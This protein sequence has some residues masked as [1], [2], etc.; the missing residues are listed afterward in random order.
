MYNDT[1]PV[2]LLRL[3]GIAGI[4]VGIIIVIFAGMADSN[5][6]F[7]FHGIY[8]GDSVDPWIQSVKA[9]PG[10]SKVI[11]SL[12][13]AGFSCFLIIGVVLYQYIQENSWQKNLS[14]VGYMIGVPVTIV[15]WIIQLSLMNHVL[16]M[17]GQ[18]PE[19]SN[20]VAVQVSFVLYFFNIINEIFGPFFIIV[21]G[22]GMMAWAALKAGVLPKW[23]CYWGIICSG[24]MILSFFWVINPAFRALGSV[25]PLHMI[26]CLVVGVFLLRRAGK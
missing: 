26:W 6:I 4:L 8:T 11:M 1:F 3:G 9:S 18:S 19:V 10:L 25:A 15:M 23:L 17:H 7:F 2:S 24:L 13:V 5:Q 22:S 14:I 12:P 16:L 20:A 21:L